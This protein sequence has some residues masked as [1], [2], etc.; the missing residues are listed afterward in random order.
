MKIESL[1]A[2]VFNGLFITLVLPVYLTLR[3]G[4]PEFL[5]VY[6]PILAFWAGFIYDQIEGSKKGGD[7]R[8]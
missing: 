1:R 8:E 5:L 3:C 7:T 4:I 6:A 2:I